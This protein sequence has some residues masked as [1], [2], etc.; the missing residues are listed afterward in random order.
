MKPAA[1]TVLSSTELFE[2]LS[3]AELA[4]LEPE[5]EWMRLLGGDI[6]FQQGEIGDC[7]YVVANGRLRAIVE[8]PNGSE[9]ILGEAGYIETCGEMAVLTGDVRSATVRAV[10]DTSLLRLSTQSFH[11]LME[12]HPD[13]ALTLTRRIIQRF[14]RA[15]HGLPPARAGAVSTIAVVGI[16]PETPLAGFARRL[17]ASLGAA[18][19]VLHLDGAKLDAALG[20]GATQIPR[21]HA[22]NDE[23]LSWLSEQESNYRFLL[24]E[25]DPTPS[26]WS[27]RCVRQADR[28]LLVGRAALPPQP[29]PA[30]LAMARRGEGE[31]CRKELVLL[32][33]ERKP[34]YPGT[35][36]WLDARRVDAHHH[37]VETADADYERLVRVVT[38][39][40][41]GVVLGGGGARSFAQIGMLRAIQEAGIAIDLVGG[42]SMGA[43][44]GAQWAM[45]W[46]AAKMESYNRETWRKRW[47]IRDYT[48]PYM[49]LIK[50]R[51][52]EHATREIYGEA[53]I[54]DFALNFF[55]CSSNL[56]RARL[57][58][59]RRGMILRA[60][61][62]TICVPGLAPP[63]FENGDLHVDG[64]AL[65]NLPIDVMRESCDGTVIAMDVSP[66]VD[67]AVDPLLTRNPSPWQLLFQDLTR[68]KRKFP[69]PTML[70]ILS[71]SSSLS[72]L[73]QVERLKPEATLYLHPPLEK[74]SIFDFDHLDALI[75]A[76]YEYAAPLI[77]Q[78]RRS[79]AE[80]KPPARRTRTTVVA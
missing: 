3:A 21:D 71:R 29:G 34:L 66:S 5:L 41:T 61:G 64:A 35:R 25:A 39:R 53:Q 67:L 55:C 8:H 31:I 13:M 46:D 63:I 74:Y 65:D 72:S 47:P 1:L 28:I 7:L 23:I 4:E 37:V 11:R 43:Y 10:R 69:V 14:Q 60:L 80:T 15:M 76:G 56:T 45:G 78:W 79:T 22:R 52:F 18:G 62:A 68:T 48:L 49:A 70:E 57:A 42:T 9:T 38:G 27:S 6:L 30:E 36:Q 16:H 58:V 24:Y 75:R 19:S 20:P 26:A 2:G 12:S 17:A 33:A 40:A 50:G 77:T 44:L 54:E 59:H 73:Q 51:R 32:H